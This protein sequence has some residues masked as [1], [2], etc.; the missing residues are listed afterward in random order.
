MPEDFVGV[1]ENF[2][3]FPYR[4]VIGFTTLPSFPRFTGYEREIIFPK[5]FKIVGEGSMT[6]EFRGNYSVL[7][8]TTKGDNYWTGQI[9]Y[10]DRVYPELIIPL[11]FAFIGAVALDLLRIILTPITKFREIFKYLRKAKKEWARILRDP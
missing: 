4:F 5:A 11:F 1:D 8:Y 7:R 2:L 6:K 9:Y 3:I 10:E